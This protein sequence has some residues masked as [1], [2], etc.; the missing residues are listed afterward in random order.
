MSEI[1]A[2]LRIAADAAERLADQYRHRAFGGAEGTQSA[3]VTTDVVAAD[4][5][6]AFRSFARMLREGAGEAATAFPK[7]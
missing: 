7:K 5:S 6:S 4:L 1:S 2:D 3:S